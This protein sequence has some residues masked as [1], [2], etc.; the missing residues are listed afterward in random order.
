MK[1]EKKSNLADR[2]LNFALTFIVALCC[3]WILDKT[4]DHFGW[5]ASLFLFGAAYALFR[6]GDSLLQR[7]K[8]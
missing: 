6:L 3:V 2:L 8:R 4:H 7:L 1:S 5:F